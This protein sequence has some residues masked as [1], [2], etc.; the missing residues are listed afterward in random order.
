MTDSGTRGGGKQL[1]RAQEKAKSYIEEH[2][3]EKTISEMLNS[4]VHARDPKPIIF[5][6]S[7]FC[8]YC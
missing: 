2:N 6:V 4:L 7:H 1:S 3:V 5:M 8:C